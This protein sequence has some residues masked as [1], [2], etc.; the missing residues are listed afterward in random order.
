MK[1]HINVFLMSYRNE[2]IKHLFDGVVDR[3]A[4]INIIYAYSKEDYKIEVEMLKE[5]KE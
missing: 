1:Y 2:I 4:L 3:D 5:D